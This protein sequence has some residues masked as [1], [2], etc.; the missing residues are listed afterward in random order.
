M[1]T[2]LSIDLPTLATSA[3]K[4]NVNFEYI[5]LYFEQLLPKF[6][7]NNDLWTLYI[8]LSEDFCTD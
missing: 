1:L 5:Q 3:D 2:L 4:K 6:T 8:Q 7:L